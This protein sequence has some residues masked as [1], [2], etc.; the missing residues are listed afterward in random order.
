[1]I[2]L[3]ALSREAFGEGKAMETRNVG[4]SRLRASAV[5]ED[6]AE[7]GRIGAERLA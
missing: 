7:V 3:M 2:A 4:R 5:A 1:M 6:I